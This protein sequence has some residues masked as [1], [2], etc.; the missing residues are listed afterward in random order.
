MSHPPT[1]P[2]IYPIR[3][4]PLPVPTL[5][6]YASASEDVWSKEGSDGTDTP[7]PLRSGQARGRDSSGVLRRQ[8]GLPESSSV[9]LL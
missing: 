6:P 2:G 9:A 4:L 1:G 5:H 7:S 8:G 3:A